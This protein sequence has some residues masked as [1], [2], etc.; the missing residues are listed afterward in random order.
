M[1]YQ[2]DVRSTEHTRVWNAG[3]RTY[4]TN[5][6]LNILISH[7][8]SWH[9]TC[10]TGMELVVV[11]VTSY[12]LFTDT[13]LNPKYY[14]RICKVF[15]LTSLMQEPNSLSISLFQPTHLPKPSNLLTPPPR[16]L[17]KLP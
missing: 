2:R 3:N 11:V 6:V 12:F 10:C 13:R 9:R 8:R 14:A 16:P 5:M 15:P 4:H 1:I 17:N 7:S